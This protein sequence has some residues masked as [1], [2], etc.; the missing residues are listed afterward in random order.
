MAQA[1]VH[2]QTVT[3]ALYASLVAERLQDTF[4]YDD[5]SVLYGVVLVYVQVAFGLYRQI[6]SA[7][8]GN[9][10]E[11]MVKESYPSID[12]AL[13]ASIYIQTHVDRGL[14]GISLDF[15][16]TFSAQQYL[17]NLVPRRAVVAQDKGLAS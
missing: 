12:V 16:Y 14:A 13:A 8:L 10:L 5:S 11:H 15:G 3:I 6:Y 2:R 9:L 4:A 17:R 1:V 7:M